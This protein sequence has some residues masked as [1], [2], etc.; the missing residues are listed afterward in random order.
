MQSGSLM[1]CSGFPVERPLHRAGSDW[2]DLT[3]QNLSGYRAR[4]FLVAAECIL[5]HVS[6]A[7]CIY[8]N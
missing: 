6:L 4:L 2:P 7:L 8:I 5:E 1:A 3:Y